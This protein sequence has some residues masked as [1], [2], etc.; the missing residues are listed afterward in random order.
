MALEDYDFVRYDEAQMAHIQ[1]HIEGK[2]TL[3][4]H[5]RRDAFPNAKAL[6]D[7][8]CEQVR[9][10]NGKRT[11]VEFDLDRE[12]GYDSLVSLQ[13]LDSRVQVTKEPRGR[14]GYLVNV[15]TGVEKKPTRH[16]VI[17]AGPL[18]QESKHGFYT[19]F[20][21]INAPPLPATREQLLS[22]G[23]KDEELEKAVELNKQY[24]DFW[25]KHAFVKD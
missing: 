7:F 16:I 23:Y 9:E 11:I 21:G 12:I 5:F 17:V 8:A 19:I 4:S 22:M 13:E 2:S 15:V 3:G 10:Y 6:I 14:S 20:P 25:A 24:E 1:E 18:K